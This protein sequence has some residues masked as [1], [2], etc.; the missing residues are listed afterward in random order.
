M[1]IPFW[2]IIIAAVLA[3]IIT[4]VATFF[5]VKKIFEKQ[6]EKNPPINPAMIRALYT[7]MGRKPSESQIKNVMRS[8]QKHK[9]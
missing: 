3:V 7:S 1:D 5:I 9:K 6:M 8:V 2:W 4:A